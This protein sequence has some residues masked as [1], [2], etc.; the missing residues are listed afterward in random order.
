MCDVLPSNCLQGSDTANNGKVTPP[1]S[2][3]RVP[4]VISCSVSINTTALRL[5][6]RS[7]QITDLTVVGQ[8]LYI[9]TSTTDLH[10]LLRVLGPFLGAP[11]WNCKLFAARHRLQ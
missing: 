3:P 5:V 11:D 9:T 7:S 1:P 2:V 4:C 6:V 8:T 10:G